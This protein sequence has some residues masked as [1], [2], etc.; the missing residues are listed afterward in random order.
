MN[1]QGARKRILEIDVACQGTGKEITQV[2]TQ[3]GAAIVKSLEI[4]CNRLTQI[5]IGLLTI[6]SLLEKANN[7]EDSLK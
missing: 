6:A 5:S 1:T 2:A 7:L 4:V 3:D